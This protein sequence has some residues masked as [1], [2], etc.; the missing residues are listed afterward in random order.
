MWEWGCWRRACLPRRDQALGLCF[1]HPPPL[2]GCC[3]ALPQPRSPPSIIYCGLSH[4]LP[5]PAL[6]LKRKGHVFLTLCKPNAPP[7][8]TQWLPS[9]APLLGRCTCLTAWPAPLLPCMPPAGDAQGKFFLA[10]FLPFTQACPSSSLCWESPLQPSESLTHT[11]H[12]THTAFWVF[13]E[14]EH[15]LTCIFWFTVFK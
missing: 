3:H 13:I 14:Q 2:P 7:H 4:L 5:W 9:W 11:C 12:G 15:N 10:V 8:L 6:L 1:P